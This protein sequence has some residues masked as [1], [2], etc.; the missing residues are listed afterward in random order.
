MWLLEIDLSL[1]LCFKVNSLVPCRSHDLLRNLTS[2]IFEFVGALMLG[3]CQF[4][5]K[6]QRSLNRFG[7][8]D[9]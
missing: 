1:A 9:C 5:V 7:I 8:S 6:W 2:T 3:I 4:S